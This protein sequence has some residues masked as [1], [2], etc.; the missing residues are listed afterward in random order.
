MIRSFL[1]LASAGDLLRDSIELGSEAWEENTALSEEAE[2]RFETTG[3]QIGIMMGQV[4]DLAIEV[5]DILLPTLVGLVDNLKGVLDGVKDWAT[6]HPELTRVI[7]IGTAAIG[8]FAL[9]LGPLLI[10]LPGLIAIAPL[11]GTAI[12]LMFGPVGLAILAV[13]ALAAAIILNWDFVKSATMR[14]WDF[15]RPIFDSWVGWLLP[16]G[17]LVKGFLFLK[18][19]WREVVDAMGQAIAGGVNFIIDQLNRMIRVFNNVRAAFGQDAV[20]EIGKVES[21]F[22]LVADAAKAKADRLNVLYTVSLP[23]LVEAMDEATESGDTLAESFGR[24]GQTLSGIA[25]EGDIRSILLTRDFIDPTVVDE[26]SAAWLRNIALVDGLS[27]GQAVLNR[28]LATTSSASSDAA[29]SVLKASEAYLASLVPLS[30]LSNLHIGYNHLLSETFNGLIDATVAQERY[31]QETGEFEEALELFTKQGMLDYI[32][33]LE[34]GEVTIEDF[35]EAFRSLASTIADSTVP[36]MEAAEEA[37]KHFNATLSI[38]QEAMVD[39]R[40]EAILLAAEMDPLKNA[41]DIFVEAGMEPMITSLS[42]G[43][44]TMQEFLEVARETEAQMKSLANAQS[45]LDSAGAAVIDAI[46]RDMAIRRAGNLGAAFAAAQSSG[47]GAFDRFLRS[48]SGQN[49]QFL[50][51]VG[52]LRGVNIQPGDFGR[53]AV[54]GQTVIIFEGDVYGLDDFEDAVA[55]AVTRGTESGRF[56][57]EPVQSRVG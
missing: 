56:G 20:E 13:V 15:I 52:L 22:H 51:D 55:A 21:V 54:G 19:N 33:A 45:A 40:L 4:N 23:S 38:G 30:E 2:K 16:A 8:A 41:M 31:R 18:D 57:D 49:L 29:D 12:S 10:M 47:P 39:Q 5:G 24:F 32:L 3:S 35:M 11:V 42:L 28:N 36:A 25:L 34:H 17:A 43:R 44:I 46:N 1:S 6:E 37:I 14:L 26:L 53:G 50:G 7:V 27:L 9:V 48:L